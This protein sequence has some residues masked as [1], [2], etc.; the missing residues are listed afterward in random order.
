MSHSEA[1]WIPKVYELSHYHCSLMTFGKL[2]A[3][4]KLLAGKLIADGAELQDFPHHRATSQESEALALSGL[5]E[6]TEEQTASPWHNARVA[7]KSRIPVEVRS[8]WKTTNHHRLTWKQKKLTWSQHACW[9]AVWDT[10]EACC[11]AAQTNWRPTP[12][13]AS[14][15]RSYT[16]AG[17]SCSRQRVM[18]P[19]ILSLIRYFRRNK[20]NIMKVDQYTKTPHSFLISYESHEA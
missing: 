9:G 3:W 1:I 15:G 2:H 12:T 19:E 8:P 10:T 6:Q 20:Q 4:P 14:L 7:G 16:S 11:S 13:A 5:K 18:A 17:C